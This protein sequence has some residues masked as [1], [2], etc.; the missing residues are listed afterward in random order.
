MVRLQVAN[1]NPT[2]HDICHA[3][4]ILAQTR[5]IVPDDPAILALI[6]PWEPPSTHALRD[7]LDQLIAQG[8]L[9]R[10]HIG[11][12]AHLVL[13]GVHSEEGERDSFSLLV[14]TDVEHE[15]VM[16]YRAVIVLEVIGLL[17]LVREVMLNG[18]G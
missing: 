4:S 9:R 6:W 11:E 10:V 15:R 1:P 8:E 16:L 14:E 7:T 12:E 13:R 3:L 18:L 2:N 5:R 17:V